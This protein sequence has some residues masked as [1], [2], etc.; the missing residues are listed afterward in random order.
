MG[1]PP[2]VSGRAPVHAFYTSRS[3]I[4]GRA[5]QQLD[6]VAGLPGVKAVAA[7]PDL[8]PGKYGPVGCAI[9]AEQIPAFRGLTSRWQAVSARYRGT[10]NGLTGDGRTRRRVGRFR[11]RH[12][13]GRAAVRP[14]S[15]PL[16]TVAAT[17]SA[18]CRLLRRSLSR[19]SPRAGLTPAR[20]LLCIPPRGRTRYPDRH[21]GRRRAARSPV[22]RAAYLASHGEAVLAVLNRQD[23]GGGGGAAG[24]CPR[25]ADLPHNLASR[26]E[27]GILHRK[28]A[29]PSD[30][31][32]VPVP[33]S[34]GTLSYLVQ[35]LAAGPE[36]LASLAHGAGRQYDRSSMHGR[37]GRTKSDLL[38]LARNPFGGLVVCDDRNLL[39]EEAPDA[40]KNIAR[41]IADLTE[42]GLARVVATFRPLV[43]FKRA[44]AETSRERERGKSLREARR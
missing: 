29:A 38:R 31:G 41:V 13:A 36:T 42:C 35:P 22:T 20:I 21:C 7:M 27:D 12:A 26:R 44:R 5:V 10:G 40:Y 16:G 30:R 39:V 25:P 15:A 3:W 17:T 24:G 18:R 1:N 37:A 14:F 8:H 34:R 11:C 43:T 32:L 19:T 4:E 28:G 9:L 6:T 2:D 33:G 23:V